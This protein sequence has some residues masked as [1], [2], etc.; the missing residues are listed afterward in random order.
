MGSNPTL[1]II[2]FVPWVVVL[3]FGLLVCSL[4]LVFVV[5]GGGLGVE[6]KDGRGV[7]GLGGLAVLRVS[8]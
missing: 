6:F 1:L 8:I 4:F 3:L 2:Y 5:E 7:G